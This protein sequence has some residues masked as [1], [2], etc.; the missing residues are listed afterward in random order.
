MVR[1]KKSYSKLD[2]NNTNAEI[3]LEKD[4]AILTLV[5]CE[6]KDLMVA[7]FNRLKDFLGDT[8]SNYVIVEDDLLLE[9]IPKEFTVVGGKGL[10]DISNEIEKIKE[11]YIVVLKLPCVIRDFMK[12]VSVIEKEK[13]KLK[14]SVESFKNSMYDCF[15]D[16]H[17]LVQLWKRKSIIEK[18]IDGIGVNYKLVESIINY[19]PN[20]L[21]N[22][23]WNMIENHSVINLMSYQYDINL[24]I[25]GSY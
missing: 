7:Y 24:S 16:S 19:I 13:I 2:L 21:I 25:R 17:G 12:T 9:K 15:L 3:P 5:E 4:I 6:N 10:K 22:G 20:L 14:S 11:E 18:G 8:F 1:R 23:K